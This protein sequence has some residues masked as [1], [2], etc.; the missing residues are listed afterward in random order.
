M[1]LSQAGSALIV[2][3]FLSLYQLVSSIVFVEV[4]QEVLIDGCKVEQ[5]HNTTMEV[6]VIVVVKMLQLNFNCELFIKDGRM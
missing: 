6:V 4:N 2:L 3:L 1:L 5:K